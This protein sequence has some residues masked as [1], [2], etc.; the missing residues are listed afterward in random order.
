MATQ[1]YLLAKALLMEL[2]SE[3]PQY[4]QIRKQLGKLY[5][6]L[7]EPESALECFRHAA[8]LNPADADTIYWTGSVR[9]RLGETVAAEAAYVEA[10]RIQPLIHRPAAK[11]PADFRILAL[12]APFA[13]NIPTEYLFRDTAYDVDTLALL[14][15]SELDAGLLKQDVHVVVNLISD[16]DQAE[17]LLL[18]VADLAGRLGKPLVNDP[19]RIQGTTRDAAAARLEG[20]AGCRVPKTFR[21][22]AG[23]DLAIATLRA[24]FSSSS[25]ILIR[26][27]GTHGGDD[28]E[29]IEDW[30]GLTTCLAQRADT[31]RYFIEYVDYRSA[32][33][34]F[35]KY[36][37]IF[38]DGRILPYHLAIAD[39][40]K[41]H[42]DS[43][44][45]SD[46]QWM[47]REEEAFLTDPTTVFNSGHYRVSREIQERIG[48]EYFGID[49]G[50]DP[51]GDLVVFEANASMLVH[52]QNEE[53]R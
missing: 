49:C 14:A 35:W 3:R 11:F 7:N 13:G 25:S 51:S 42:H 34:Y 26:P 45:M 4:A 22:T 33:G 41:V 23:T 27:V 44:G 48:L 21:Q 40:W 19:R 8:V 6:E 1:Q 43:T 36:R 37:F 2:I 9:Q 20:I 53:F 17:A 47:Q 5:F 50:L 29:K 31:D 39:D 24:V 16:A 52:D 38:V 28:F 12:F 32:D 10:A 30:A 46:H 18:R 15:S